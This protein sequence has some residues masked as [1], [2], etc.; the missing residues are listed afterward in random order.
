MLGYWTYNAV[1]GSLREIR[2]A[3][4]RGL[5]DSEVNA[6]RVWIREEIADAER[7][8]RDPRVRESVSELART[9]ARGASRDDLCTGAA[10]AKVEEVLRPLLRDIG[11]ATF[12]LTDRTG[13]L[14]ATRYPEYCG[15]SVNRERFFPLLEPVFAGAS[16]FLRP[17]VDA[18][19]VAAA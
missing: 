9:A 16:R 2:A 4:M 14:L 15:P 12:N 7:L 6:L 18:D 1:E 3:T 19:R 8:A 5:L 11:D 13:R 17:M 10:R